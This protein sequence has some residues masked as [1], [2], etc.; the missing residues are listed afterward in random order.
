MGVVASL[1]SLHS[2][3]GRLSDSML[4]MDLSASQAGQQYKGKLSA[5]MSGDFRHRRFALSDIQANVARSDASLP[6]RSMKL[7]VTGAAVLDVEREDVALTLVSR[8]DESTIKASLGASPFSNPHWRVNVVVDQLDADRY[9]P[10]RAKTAEATPEREL[11]FSLLKALNASG[12]MKIGSLKLYGIQANDVRLAFRAGGGKLEA[13]PLAASLYQGTTSGDM[14]LDVSGPSVAFRQAVN[15]VSIGPL[16]QDALDK[17]VLEGK[18]SVIVDVAASGKTVSSMKKSLH[19]S[20]ALKLRDGAV[21]GI[22][23]AATLRE[24]KSR[25][26]VMKGEKVQAANTREKTDFSELTASFDIR[27]GIAHNED[28]VAKSPLLRLAGAGDVDIG[29]E[30]L[31]YLARAT[32]VGT[33][34]GQG[35]RELAALR[36]VTVPVRISG[37]FKAPQYALDFNAMAGENIRQEIRSRTQNKLKEG[38]KGLFR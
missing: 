19:G 35:G 20:A 22:N 14:S 38:F 18:G 36:G 13:S 21:K 4:S 37:P 11:D 10:P 23:L 26:A 17:D 25:L 6:G 30:Q 33:L 15:D 1:P 2:K 27:E 16:L 12:S 34:E 24:A 31:N 32:V 5:Q 28:L 3:G 7:A 9:L 29:A 8:L